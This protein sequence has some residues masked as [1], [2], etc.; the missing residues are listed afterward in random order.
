MGNAV[1]DTEEEEYAAM[2]PL[3]GGRPT[4]PLFLRNNEMSCYDI[5]LC[6]K[7]AKESTK[8]F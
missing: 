2:G 7:K 5:K 8:L 6:T 3:G 1:T 4:V